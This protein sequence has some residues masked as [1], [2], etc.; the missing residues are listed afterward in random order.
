MMK[1]KFTILAICIFCTKIAFSG[2]VPKTIA[3]E[4]SE[5]F[6]L[7]LSR[8]NFNRIFV[9]GEKITKL[10]YPE[11]T[12]LV[13]KSDL[14]QSD[15]EEASV[16]LK[17]VFDTPITIFVSTDKNHHFA[18]TVKANNDIGKTF[19]MVAKN[20]TKL[21][22]VSH[23][24]IDVSEV[25]LVMDALKAGEHPEGFKSAK[26]LFR[27]FFVKKNI[28]V[29]LIKHYLGSSDEAYV[30]K[31]ENTGN[32]ATQVSTALFSHKKARSLVLSEDNLEPKKIAYL[33]GI[34]AN[35]I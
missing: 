32:I 17:P 21:K 1:N 31:V 27:P 18:L 2:I 14:N 11:G 23:N 8:I 20:Q 25:D 7:A 4:D 16:Y 5:H 22:Y 19:K 33:Y 12:F 6:E 24:T 26:V 15:S 35:E 10:R 3:F 29:S 9:D 34:Y 28:K 13:D 30:Y